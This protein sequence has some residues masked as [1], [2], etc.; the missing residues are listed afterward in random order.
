MDGP[1]ECPPGEYQLILRTIDNQVVCEGPNVNVGSGPARIPHIS[2]R[3]SALL[4]RPALSISDVRLKADDDGFV[5]TFG[6]KNSGTGPLPKSSEMPVK[7]DYRVLIDNREI[8]RGG[9]I[10]PAFQ[11]PPGW[12]VKAFVVPGRRLYT[13]SRKRDGLK[14]RT[15][16]VVSIGV[17]L[18]KGSDARAHIKDIE[19]RNNIFERTF[20]R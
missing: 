1:R 16:H 5:I 12:E 6:Y 11:A 18:K 3:V 17:I 10:F 9:L 20:H 4:K 14:G 19:H 8:S 13:L 15:E 7:P 2:E